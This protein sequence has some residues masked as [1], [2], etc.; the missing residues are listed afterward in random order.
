MPRAPPIQ[1]QA[2][3]AAAGLQELR[4][5]TE[6]DNEYV[7]SKDN[8][9]AKADREILSILN[10]VEG[11][12][13]VDLGLTMRVVYQ[14]AWSTAGDPFGSTNPSELLGELTNFWNSNRGSVARD[15]VH[16]WTGK[17]LDN[18]TIGTAYLEALCRFAGN[19]RAA[20]GLSKGVLSDKQQ[21]AITAHEIGHN[22]GATHPNQQ[23][24]PVTECNNTVMGSSVNTEPQL[25][26]CQFSRD[27]IAKYLTSSAGCLATGTSGLKFALSSSFF[28]GANPQAMVSVDFNGDGKQDLATANESGN[29][30]VLLGADDGALH[31]ATRSPFLAGSAPI[32][33]V[34]VDLNRDGAPD[35]AVADSTGRVNVFL[36]TGDGSFLKGTW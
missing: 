15:V 13:E 33:F 24:P 27:E 32:S 8:N 4:I 19:G 16:M 26:F 3:A 22:L 2:S 21:V 31:E 25:T 1:I 18:S 30:N 17:Q 12:F 35:L 20:Y 10:K 11:L 7:I 14:S 5:A 36:G 28:I 34:A 29:V 6:A 9:A 23:S